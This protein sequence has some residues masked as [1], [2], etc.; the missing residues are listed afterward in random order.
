M[1][2]W[3]HKKVLEQLFGFFIGLLNLALNS[4]MDYNLLKN[5]KFFIYLGRQRETK[6]LFLLGSQVKQDHSLS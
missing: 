3:K 1:A 6:H 5:E 4:T 2:L